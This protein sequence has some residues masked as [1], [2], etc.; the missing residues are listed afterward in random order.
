[1]CGR[2]RPLREHGRS[3]V[4]RERRVLNLAQAPDS[5]NRS[6]GV[7]PF[8][9]PLKWPNMIGERSHMIVRLQRRT[10]PESDRSWIVGAQVLTERGL[11][12]QWFIRLRLAEELEEARRYGYPLSVVILSP[13]L[14]AGERDAKSRV[15]IG[16]TAARS[17]ARASDLIGWLDG[18]DILVVLPHTDVT[19]ADGAIDRWREEMR[20]QTEPFGNLKWL[21]ASIQDDGHFY[22]A[23]DFVAAALHNFRGIG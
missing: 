19:G 15:S 7:A 12:R 20:R 17:A 3:E 8:S 23:D 10:P 5:K 6:P 1:M 14:V 2:W 4:V 18:D 11:L 9:G 13:M 16:I 21:A 22:D